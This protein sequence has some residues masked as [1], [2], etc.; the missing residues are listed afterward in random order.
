VISRV[1]LPKKLV[2]LYVDSNLL[3]LLRVDEDDLNYP[4]FL[5]LLEAA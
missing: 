3:D 4:L 5:N 1:T 2:R